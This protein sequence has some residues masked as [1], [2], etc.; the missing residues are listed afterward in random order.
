MSEIVVIIEPDGSTKI[1]VNGHQGSGCAALTKAVA[2]AIAGSDRDGKRKAE[3]FQEEV[4]NS[5]SAGKTR[6]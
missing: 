2:D 5:V 4:V 3:F 6:W 1:E